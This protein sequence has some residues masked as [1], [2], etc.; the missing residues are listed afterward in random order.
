MN[1]VMVFWVYEF[2]KELKNTRLVGRLTR[3]VSEC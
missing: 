3:W 1:E 2:T